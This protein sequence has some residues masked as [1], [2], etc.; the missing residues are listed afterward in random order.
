MRILFVSDVVNCW[1]S[2]IWYHRI[3]VPYRGLSSRGHGVKQISIGATVADEFME[4][5]DSVVMGRIYPDGT[6]PLELMIKYKK[7][8]KKVVYDIDDDYWAVDPSNPS[9]FVSNV[10]KDQYEGLIKEADAITTPS[11]VLG[12]K[13][14]KLCKKKVFICPNAIDFND[15]RERPHQNDLLIKDRE[16]KLKKLKELGITK[17]ED[18]DI[19]APKEDRLVIGYMGAASHWKDLA[20]VLPALRELNKKYDFIFAIHGIVGGDFD[21]EIQTYNRIRSQNTEPEKNEYYD[22]A[23]KFYDGLKGLSMGHKGFALPEL[24]P[25]KLSQSDFDIGIAPLEDTEFNRGKSCIKYYEYAAIGTPTLASNVEPYKSECTYLADNTTKDWYNK[26]E[27]L[28]VDKKFREELAKKQYN[29][30]KEN[31]SI[32]KVAIDWEIACQRESKP[33]APKVLNQDKSFLS[34]LKSKLKK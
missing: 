10:F 22:E 8:G 34:R 15:Y 20:I 1:K 26:L 28:I 3:E 29:W 7:L 31:R 25:L 30:V 12:K 18:L 2:G 6:N 21:S 27:K 13:I 33:G 14:Q 17:K 23:L 19:F 32:E 4:Y 9:R 24:N 11:V 16:E 5:P